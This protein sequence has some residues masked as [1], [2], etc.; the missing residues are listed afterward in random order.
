MFNSTAIAPIDRFLRTNRLLR[1][2]DT[3]PEV[4]LTLLEVLKKLNTGAY[5]AT[6]LVSSPTATTAQ[7]LA[8]EKHLFA[9]DVQRLNE[10]WL[11]A[12]VEALIASLDPHISF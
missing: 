7:R 2:R 8:I 3:L 5:A 4:G 12:D 6:A 1:L 9:V 10:A 11:A